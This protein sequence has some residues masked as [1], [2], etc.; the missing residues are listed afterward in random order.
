MANENQDVER[1]VW[2]RVFAQPQTKP[3][4]DDLRMLVLSSLEAAGAYRYLSRI[5]TGRARELARRLWEEEQETAACLRGLHRLSGGGKERPKGISAMQ[6]RPDKVLEKCYHRA[7]RTV[8]EYTARMVDSEF[9]SVF[10]RLAAREE[11]HCARIA[12]LLGNNGQ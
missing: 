8:T 12:Q 5:L 10:R 6:D 3:E 4:G 1:Q 11:E 2:Q 9:G 7:R